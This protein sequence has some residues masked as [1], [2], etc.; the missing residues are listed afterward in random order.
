MIVDLLIYSGLFFATIPIWV[1]LYKY[2]LGGILADIYISKIERGEIDLNYLLDEGGVFDEL[3]VRVVTLLKQHLLAEMG[4]VSRQSGLPDE[5]IDTMD[6][7]SMGIEA[8][9]ELLKAVGMKKPPPLL[10]IKLAQALGNMVSGS[11]QGETIG[12]WDKFGP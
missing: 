7:I 8:S 5:D 10:Q 2:Y 1:F 11:D 6:P 3:S 4:Q 9:G 12:S